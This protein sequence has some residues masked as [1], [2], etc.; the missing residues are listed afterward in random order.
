MHKALHETS[1]MNQTC[2]LLSQCLQIYQRYSSVV[3]ALLSM[4]ES[5]K[6]KIYKK[7]IPYKKENGK[8]RNLTGKKL[9]P[10]KENAK[11]MP[12]EGWEI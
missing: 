10:M 3:E 9:S 12:A 7:L 2:I 11:I 8:L 6:E 5:W 1:K 4:Y